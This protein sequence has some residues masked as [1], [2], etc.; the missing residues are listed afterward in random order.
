[1]ANL[2]IARSQYDVSIGYCSYLDDNVVRRNSETPKQD[3]NTCTLNTGYSGS[4]IGKDCEFTPAAV[5][6]STGSSE[7]KQQKEASMFD[8][9]D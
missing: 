2:L 7:K 4:S 9:Y 6:A 5:A 1:M 3:P 8:D